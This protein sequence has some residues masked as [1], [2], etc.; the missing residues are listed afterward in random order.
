[1]SPDAC[2]GFLLEAPKKLSKL[3]G[4]KKTS[5]RKFSRLIT[6]GWLQQQQSKKIQ[7]VPGCHPANVCKSIWISNRVQDKPPVSQNDSNKRG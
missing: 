2:P 1:M 7:H 4:E 6:S 5:K 3:L